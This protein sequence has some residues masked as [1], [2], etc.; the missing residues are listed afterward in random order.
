MEDLAENL[1]K[2][3]RS[4]LINTLSKAME[5]FIESYNKTYLADVLHSYVKGRALESTENV[6]FSELRDDNIKQLNQQS[7]YKISNLLKHK[8]NPNK[9]LRTLSLLAFIF[10][11]YFIGMSAFAISTFPKNPLPILSIHAVSFLEDHELTIQFLIFIASIAIP[12]WIRRYRNNQIKERNKEIDNEIKETKK[13]LEKRINLEMSK[14]NEKFE[15]LFAGYDKQLSDGNDA[16]YL[17]QKSELDDLNKKIDE[18]YDYLTHNIPSKYQN[19]D[20]VTQS[21]SVLKNGEAND[22]SSVVRVWKE[23][24]H[25]AKME[26][27]SKAEKEAAEKGAAANEEAR[28]AAKQTARNTAEA[29]R[30][31]ERR[32]AAAEEQARQ[33]QWQAAAAE[34]NASA[35]EQLKKDYENAHRG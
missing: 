34:R 20:F 23:E 6:Q 24:Q 15:N 3:N 35:T 11:L 31:G 22:W 17:K 4:E 9:F 18:S 26:E 13:D 12:V 10:I 7:E 5:Y 30:A 29:A 32:A 2:K 33:A 27:D 25:R 16:E 8:K 21:I 19:Y 14:Y 28:D 1:M